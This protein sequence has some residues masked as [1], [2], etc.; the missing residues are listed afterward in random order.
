MSGLSSRMKDISALSESLSNMFDKNRETVRQLTEKSKTIERL[1]FFVR[2]PQ[3]LQVS[4]CVL[5]FFQSIKPDFV[6][7]Y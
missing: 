1:Q 4:F 3:I 7:I 6:G 5:K 2:L